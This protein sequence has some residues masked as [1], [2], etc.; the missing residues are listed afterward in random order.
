MKKNKQQLIK[1]YQ[2]DLEHC[3][4]LLVVK[5]SKIT[6]EN[7]K[8]IKNQMRHI[9]TK[10]RVVKNSLVQ[11]AIRNTAFEPLTDLLHYST[12]FFYSDDPIVSFR[13]IKKLIST[14]DFDLSVKAAMIDNFLFQGIKLGELSNMLSLNEIQSKIISLINLPH[15]K[16]ISFFKN[17]GSR[18]VTIIKN[19]S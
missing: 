1:S 5:S 13:A 2:A 18:L 10:V 17:T 14:H 3:R 6:V 15:L 7:Y 4:Y 8:H 9:G 12:M 19:K 11:V 16:H